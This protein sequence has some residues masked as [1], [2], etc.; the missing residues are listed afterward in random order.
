MTG[1]GFL[2]LI[3]ITLRKQASRE[4]PKA[5]D[6][7]LLE[8]SFLPRYASGI[9]LRIDGANTGYAGNA[10]LESSPPECGFVPG[11]SVG[12][13]NRGAPH[14]STAAPELT[15]KIAEPLLCD[16][17]ERER[18]NGATRNENLRHIGGHVGGAKLRI[19][20][21]PHLH[22]SIPPYLSDRFGDLPPVSRPR[23]V[24]DCRF[25]SSFHWAI[26]SAAIF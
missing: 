14:S 12:Y 6:R 10:S 25:Q 2:V 15:R 3:R 20:A 4:L 22:T 16:T 21:D 26:A 23:V 24:K 17:T 11:Q 18:P 19:M 7:T 9:P 8:R 5:L 1:S 13:K